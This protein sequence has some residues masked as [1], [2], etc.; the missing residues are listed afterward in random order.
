MSGGRKKGLKGH[1]QPKENGGKVVRNVGSDF[2]EK[3]D[4]VR[5]DIQNGVELGI[6]TERLLA[7]NGPNGRYMK[8]RDFNS[9][10]P[11]WYKGSTEELCPS[12]FPGTQVRRV[13]QPVTVK[14]ERNMDNAGNEN[15]G[16]NQQG[17]P[18]GGGNVART[19]GE[20]AAYIRG[21]D[22]G[23]KGRVQLA[24]QETGNWL[25][26]FWRKYKTP[27]IV[28]GSV[29]GT[30]AVQAG[31]AT[32]AGKRGARATFRTPGGETYDMGADNT[33]GGNTTGGT[34]GGGG[35]NTTGGN[36]S[37]GGRGR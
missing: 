37:G 3:L 9:G 21:V 6:A 17:N 19:A 1:S 14:Q 30:I 7:L 22:D 5:K 32:F 18:Q 23:I 15:A 8:R 27:L 31:L 13:V 20:E 24:A 28:G 29:I 2:P 11:S 10:S 34:T 16:N 33:G 35:G 26:R 25:T 4:K 12:A 36:T